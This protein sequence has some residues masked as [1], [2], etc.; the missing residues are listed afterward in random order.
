MGERTRSFSTT[1]KVL[2]RIVGEFFGD[3]WWCDDKI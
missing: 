1:A 3:M 2:P